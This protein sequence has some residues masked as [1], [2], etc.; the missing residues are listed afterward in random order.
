MGNDPN[1]IVPETFNYP[2]LAYFNKRVRLVNFYF[3]AQ[4]DF[5]FKIP[6]KINGKFA[7]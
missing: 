1:T 5:Y 6:I 3:W 2:R 7:H 4:I